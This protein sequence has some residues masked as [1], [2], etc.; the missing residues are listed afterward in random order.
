MS[1]TSIDAKRVGE[2]ASMLY[3]TLWVSVPALNE[4]P[5]YPID[6]TNRCERKVENSKAV[7]GRDKHNHRASWVACH[8]HT[9]QIA[10]MQ[11][12]TSEESLLL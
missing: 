9:T 10:G 5:A 8:L 12:V 6:S 3:N 4:S 7:S 2:S 1:Y 11:F